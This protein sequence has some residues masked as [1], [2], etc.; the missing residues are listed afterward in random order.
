MHSSGK[1][2]SAMYRTPVMTLGKLEIPT[3]IDMLLL[4]HSGIWPQ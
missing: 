1:R 4:H 3:F 2:K